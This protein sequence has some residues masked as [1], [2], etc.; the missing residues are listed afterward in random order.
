MDIFLQSLPYSN[1]KPSGKDTCRCPLPNVSLGSAQRT[2]WLCPTYPLALPYVLPHP[3]LLTPIQQQILLYLKENH[4]GLVFRTTTTH[5]PFALTSNENSFFRHVSRRLTEHVPVKGGSPALWSSKQP[6]DP[7][8]TFPS[9]R[10]L[11]SQSWSSLPTDSSPLCSLPLTKIPLCFRAKPKMRMCCW[12]NEQP[13]EAAAPELWGLTALQA[14][15][16]TPQC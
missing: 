11:A 14:S 5:H 12:P 16:G 15:T 7:P 2:P 1:P 8:Q 4:P 9:L 10:P 3:P 13:G 6:S